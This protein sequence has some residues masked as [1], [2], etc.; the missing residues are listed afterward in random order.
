MNIL[1]NY[2]GLVGKTIAFAHMAQFADKITLAT[3]DG[4]VLMA[5]IECDEYE[6]KKEVHIYREHRVLAELDKNAWLREQLGALGIFDLVAYKEQERLRM[7]KEQEE[8]AKRK[9]ADE[10]ATYL[11][12]HEKYG[13]KEKE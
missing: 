4:H 5:T 3:T 13:N 2:P 10:Y 7:E 6:D 9:E 8:R 12:L 11:R 1:T